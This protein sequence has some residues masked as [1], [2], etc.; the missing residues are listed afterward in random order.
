[1][2][3]GEKIPLDGIVM[4]GEAMLDTTVLTGESVPRKATILESVISGCINLNGVLTIQAT[5]TYGESTVSKI[6]DLVEHAAHKKAPTETFITKF[7]RYY[8][9][10][11]VCSAVLLAIVPPLLFGGVWMDW[12]SRA[13]IFLVISCP[14]ALVVSIPLG[15]FGGIGAASKHGILVKGGNYLE[16]LANL[17]VVVFDKTGTLTKGVFQ[18]TSIQPTQGFNTDLLLKVAAYAEDYSTH[19]IAL[20]IQ[21][22]YGM[23]IDQDQIK[24]Y[25]ELAGMGVSV[26]IKG[27]SILLGNERLMKQERIEYTPSSTIGTT[28]Y[29][30][31]DQI[32]AGCIVISDEVKS[33]SREA[34]ASLKALGV[35]K[36]V[37]LTGDTRQI[38]EGI[39]DE[40]KLDEVYANLL[41]GQKVEQVERLK[42]DKRAKRTIAFVGDGINDAPVLAMADVGIAMGALGSDAAIEAADVVLMTDE[43]S[44][45]AE[46]V[47]LARFTKRIVW[48]NI[49]MAL[50]IKFLFLF[51][52]TLGVSSLWEAVFA[53]VGVSLL[54]VL[55]SMRVLKVE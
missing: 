30:A 33:D 24:Q 23:D 2:S 13:L 9:P 26:C 17:D 4:E 52:A 5:Q 14:C 1:M 49:I 19:P 20:S 18:V 42:K 6:L 27:Q 43:P 38:A 29:I 21:K 10:I 47:T 39:A 22:E 32:Y 50:G 25:E 54:A 37:M 36:T 31:I 34:I 16:A 35:Q 11:V 51:L 15:F 55:N 48:Q 45:L 44:K 7:A 41:P 53:D 28:V 40:L 3:S 8:T 46:A 12:I